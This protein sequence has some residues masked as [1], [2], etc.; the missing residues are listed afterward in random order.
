MESWV[1]AT[2][3]HGL[4][5]HCEEPLSAMV[6]MAVCAGLDVNMSMTSCAGFTKEQ[7]H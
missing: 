6:A 3:L 4:E 1:Q 2:P 5:S 7:L